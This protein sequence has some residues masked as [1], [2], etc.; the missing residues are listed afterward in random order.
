MSALDGHGGPPGVSGQTP[1]VYGQVW[2]RVMASLVVLERHLWLNLTEIKDADR[3][4]FLDS[5][6]ST[7]GLFSPVV[8]D[9]AESFTAAQK[10]SQVT[11]C[12]HYIF[13]APSH[14][15]TVQ[16][17]QPA[18]QCLQP[19]SQSQ[20]QSIDSTLTSLSISL[21]SARDPGLR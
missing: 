6:I 14:Q 17:Q 15:K 11:S 1:P 13:A 8:D 9:F 3:T 5:P 21:L 18:K 12:P 20:H 10:S 2:T 19:L 7:T 4:A 16:T